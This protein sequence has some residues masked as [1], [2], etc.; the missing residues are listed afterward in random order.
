MRVTI[1]GS[2]TALPSATRFPAAVIVEAGNEVV[3]VD[4]GPGVGRRL[5]AAGVSV[6]D[7]STILLTHYHPDHSAG[8]VE[9]LFA[10]RSPEL[11][12]TRPLKIRGGE[13][14]LRLLAGLR[15][16]WPRWLE[17]RG[18]PFDEAELQPGHLQLH[19][20][21]VIATAVDHVQE[22]L[23]YRLEETATG[24]SVCVSGDVD[25]T[26]AL[27]DAA[28]DIDLLVCEAPY[29]HDQAHR[30]HLSGRMAGEAALAAGV[31]TLCLTHLYPGSPVAQIEAEARAAFGGDVV[32]AEDLLR[33]DLPTPA[34]P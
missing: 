32:M 4:V 14:L 8:L 7:V 1:L 31:R 9:F 23:A 24:A 15:A 20:V 22:S 19:G 25:S 3:L 18:D 6:A 2:G 34:H 30:R 26:S 29:A 16:V 11:D 12:R 5:A 27:I 17:S 33:F 13:G 28:R 10:L 21:K